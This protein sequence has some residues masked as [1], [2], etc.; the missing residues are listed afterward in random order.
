MPHCIVCGAP[1][2]KT[3]CDSCAGKK[4]QT[5]APKMHVVSE[6]AAYFFKLGAEA[7]RKTVLVA[8]R[9]GYDGTVGK[10][11]IATSIEA[12]RQHE[13]E[14]DGWSFAEKAIAAV[15]APIPEPF[16]EKVMTQS[17]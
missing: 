9:E 11:K 14:A 8:L 17:A 2:Y 12:R 5:I 6:D 1:G 7:M 15:A 4:N 16:P 13:N 3:P 10:V